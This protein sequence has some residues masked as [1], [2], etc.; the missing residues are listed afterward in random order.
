MSAHYVNPNDLDTD[1]FLFSTG[2][3][4]YFTK[5]SLFNPQS[6]KGA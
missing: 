4:L 3:M 2:Y 5:P 1:H 6:N